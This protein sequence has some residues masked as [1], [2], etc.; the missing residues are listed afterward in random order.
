MKQ[1]TKKDW[2]A[3]DHMQRNGMPEEQL[4]KYQKTLFDLRN[5]DIPEDAECNPE[6]EAILIKLRDDA[7]AMVKRIQKPSTG[8]DKG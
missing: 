7:R 5:L 1:L 3:I 8:E 4:K 6:F 2:D